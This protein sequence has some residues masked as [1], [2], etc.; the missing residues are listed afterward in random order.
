[1]S[2]FVLG[3]IGGAAGFLVGGWPGAAIFAAGFAAAELSRPR[4]R[5]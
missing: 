2:A 5:R 1:M 3:I 4:P